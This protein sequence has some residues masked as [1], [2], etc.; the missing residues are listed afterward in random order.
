MGGLAKI[1]GDDVAGAK[2]YRSI[3]LISISLI[4]PFVEHQPRLYRR[5]DAILC[6]QPLIVLAVIPETICRQEHEHNQGQNCDDEHIC[7]EQ[8]HCEL[9]G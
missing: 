3:V 6:P 9:V 2:G 7:K 1:G 8:I 5:A 4:A